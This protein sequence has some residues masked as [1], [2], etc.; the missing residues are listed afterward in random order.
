MS[1]PIPDSLIVKVLAG[2]EQSNFNG[3]VAG[4]P[5]LMTTGRNFSGGRTFPHLI[6][7][8]IRGSCH[9]VNIIMSPLNGILKI[10]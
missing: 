10:Y 7:I 8:R 5:L 1:I 3:E 6:S 4:S 2:T 9:P